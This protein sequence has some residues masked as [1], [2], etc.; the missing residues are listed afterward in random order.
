MDA[1]PLAR[2]TIPRFETTRFETPRF[3]TIDLLRGLSILAV[4]LLHTWIRFY[5]NSQN[6]DLLMPRWLSHILLHQ[7]GNGVTLF[8]AISGFLITTTSIR[9]FGSLAAMRPAIFY[10]IRFARIAPPLLLLIAVLSAFALAG[11]NDYVV[12]H[13]TLRGAI[14]SALT[15]TLNW[16]ESKYGWLPPVWTVLWSLSI[17]EMF[18]LFFPVTCILLL[19][20]KRGLW[21]WIA[22]LTTFVILGPFARTIWAT[23]NDI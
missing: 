12:H 6:A 13:G 4:V 7:G 10:R 21:L 18:Y 1:L 17:E 3:E 11:F 16:Y 2:P 14:L 20:R 22:L 8:F 15:F 23:G 5:S 9:R 19:A